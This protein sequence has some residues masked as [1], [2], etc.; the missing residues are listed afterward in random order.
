[1]KIR[2]VNLSDSESLK[3]I[4]SFLTDEIIQKRKE[5]QDSGKADFL[6]IDL[7]GKIFGFVFL[8]WEGKPTHPEYP[9]MED[10]YVKESERSKGY[11]QLLIKECER[12]AKEKGFT[13]IGMAVNPD[14]NC[15]ARILYEKLGYKHDGKEKYVD[16]IYNGVEDWVVDLEKEI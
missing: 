6:V 14:E 16:G 1:M 13:K 7:K 9:D 10:L 12:L 11:G 4:K 3:I 2:Q 15:K 5:L 8:K